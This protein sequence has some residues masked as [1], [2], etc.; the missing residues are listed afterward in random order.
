MSGPSVEGRRAAQEFTKL[1]VTIE[2][3][4]FTGMNQRAIVETFGFG[5]HDTH[6]FQW[7][8]WDNLAIKTLEGVMT[9]SVGDW[10]IRGLKGEFYPCKPDIFAE[11]YK[12]ADEA[13]FHHR[14]LRAERDQL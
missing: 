9:V 13:D 8:G 4:K 14:E 2:A 10:V 5:L 7:F 1:P 11:S 12:P 6:P 3:I